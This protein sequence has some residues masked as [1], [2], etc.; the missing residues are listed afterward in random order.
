MSEVTMNVTLALVDC[1]SCG[2]RFAVS[3]DWNNAKRNDHSRFFCPNGHGMSYS[4]ESELEKTR[5][6]AEA[7]Q[8][9][10]QAKLNEVRHAQLVAESERD[11]EI[12]KRRRMERRISKGVC[13]CCNRTFE[14]LA[15]HMASKHKGFGLPP[16][17]DAKQI[18]GAVQ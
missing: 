2:M 14:D 12:R 6:L 9:D 5:R 17:K 11:K 13:S 7:A 3:K 1:V 15:K 4:G 16:G 18:T 8:R 10:I